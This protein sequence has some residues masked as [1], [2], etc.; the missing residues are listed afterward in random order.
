MNENILQMLKLLRDKLPSDSLIGESNAKSDLYD[1]LAE[2]LVEEKDNLKKVEDLRTLESEEL[3]KIANQFENIRDEFLIERAELESTEQSSRLY[4]KDA[5][6]AS[7][8]VEILTKRLNVET[9]EERKKEIQ[10]Q[11]DEAKEDYE[12]NSAWAKESDENVNKIREKVQNLE[13][14]LKRL[15]ER[16]RTEMNLEVSEYAKKY[17]ETL[18]K[19]REEVDKTRG[20]LGY[21][22]IT[23]DLDSLIDDYENG[24]TTDAEVN[25]RMRFLQNQL[26]DSNIRTMLNYIDEE[27]RNLSEEEVNILSE[28]ASELRNKLSDD[29]NYILSEEEYQKEL[30]TLN[31]EYNNISKRYVNAYRNVEDTQAKINDILSNTT[32]E[33][34]L[35]DIAEKERVKLERL[36][37]KQREKMSNLNQ[38]LIDKENE[39][40][41]F[42]SYHGTINEEEKAKD[43]EKLS[44]LDNRVRELRYFNVLDPL[45]IDER[46]N[47]ILKATKAEDENLSDFITPIEEPEEII[48][49]PTLDVDEDDEIEPEFPIIKE[50]D[51]DL[52][53]PPVNDPEKIKGVREPKEGLKLKNIWK[54]A[55]VWVL[56]I[57]AVLGIGSTGLKV[58]KHLDKVNDEKE[59][60]EIV[61]SILTNETLEKLQATIQKCKDVDSSLYTQDS[62]KVMMDKVNFVEILIKNDA[63]TED[64]AVKY[65]DELEDLY[66]KLVQIN[67]IEKDDTDKSED[68]KNPVTSETNNDNKDDKDDKTNYLGD[69]EQIILMPGDSVQTPF[70]SVDYY[71]SQWD[72]KGNEIG[73]TQIDIKDGQGIVK[74]DDLV[75]QKTLDN[76][77]SSSQMENEIVWDSQI[78]SNWAEN[79]NFDDLSNGQG[80][81]M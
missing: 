60:Q 31:R 45:S 20:K 46:I 64:K 15:Q 36:L 67:K 58:K 69:N 17:E 34:H 62:Y 44:E 4:Q 65:I 25:Y 52:G 53:E 40:D 73:K 12:K 6:L 54:K 50:E 72:N 77:P 81:G 38:Q 29:N 30:N 56:I 8:K 37:S 61:N 13:K 51:M 59:I 21:L 3:N 55:K 66:S 33:G 14:D 27:Q 5:S 26:Q 48:E 71:G 35:K 1:Y 10:A 70:G 63:L 42:K 18:K 49:K 79:F 7:I 28:E 75:T 16:Y 22:N 74:D 80:L 57:L 19:R 76:A 24:R 41:K 32:L 9:D 11:L 43:A 78:D 39:I 2:K 47:S 23:K 68:I